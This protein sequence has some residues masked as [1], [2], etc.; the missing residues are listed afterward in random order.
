M[1]EKA[2]ALRELL[3]DIGP[4]GRT[5]LK[6]DEAVEFLLSWCRETRI[7]PEQPLSGTLTLYAGPPPVLAS[8]PVWIM[9]GVSQRD[10]PGR[11]AGSPLL[12]PSER[13]RLAEAEA[14][15]PSVQDKRLQREALFRRLIQTGEATQI[16]RASC[17]ER[18]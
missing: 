6:G 4:A 10:W 9:L 16:G 18:V 5:P 17:R 7:R 15:L 11:I 14:W 8:Y 12:G 13:E 1:H 3:P 2:L